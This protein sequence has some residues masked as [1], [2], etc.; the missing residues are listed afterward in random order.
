MFWKKKK[1]N[2][3]PIAIVNPTADSRMAFRV[4]PLPGAPIEFDYRGKTVMVR[5]I[6][7]TGIA[8]FDKGFREGDIQ[9]ITFHLPDEDL[10]ISAKLEILGIDRNKI[11]HCRFLNMKREF[12]NAVNKYVLARQKQ[13]LERRKKRSNG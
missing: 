5:D 4:N 8:F 12:E 10:A 11:C 6:S 9:P 1:S 2:K 3:S 13:D 7:S